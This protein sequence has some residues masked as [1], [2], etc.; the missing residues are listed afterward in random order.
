MNFICVAEPFPSFSN[1]KK[2]VIIIKKKFTSYFFSCLRF[3]LTFC[4]H[5][6]IGGGS[7]KKSPIQKKGLHEQKR[8]KKS[9]LSIEMKIKGVANSCTLCRVLFSAMSCEYDTNL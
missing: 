4:L 5:R 6:T 1:R 9:Q 2:R 8:I 3:S 7:K